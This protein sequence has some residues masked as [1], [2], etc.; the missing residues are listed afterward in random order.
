[1]YYQSELWVVFFQKYTV[2]TLSTKQHQLCLDLQE[3]T[4]PF[5]L[6]CPSLLGASLHGCGHERKSPENGYYVFKCTVVGC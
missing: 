1:M 3:Y 4:V 2:H 6:Q 5:I